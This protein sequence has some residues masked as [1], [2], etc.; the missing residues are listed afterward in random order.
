MI[1][2]TMR[3]STPLAPP[4]PRVSPMARARLCLLPGGAGPERL[5]GVWWPRSRDLVRELPA[6]VAGLDP[7]FGR[8][9]RI[10]VDTSLWPRPP[11]RIAV[12]GHTVFVS[13]FPAGHAVEICVLSN[14]AG[15]RDLLVVPPECEFA[16]AEM[17]SAAGRGTLDRPFAAGWIG[18][19]T[20][21]RDTAARQD[22]EGVWDSEGGHCR[23]EAMA[24]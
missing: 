7:R 20:A 5:D 4:V 17:A 13:R 8:I 15:R 22:Q 6:L 19:A 1:A 14:D 3:A 12:D 9:E 11:R 2:T 10:S 21:C 24:S 18:R 23:E 16:E